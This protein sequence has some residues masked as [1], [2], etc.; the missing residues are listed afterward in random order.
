LD[1]RKE[2]KDEKVVKPFQFPSFINNIEFINEIAKIAERFDYNPLK[3][4]K[5]V[6]LW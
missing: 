6:T 1:N 4:R 2:L 5:I 3:E